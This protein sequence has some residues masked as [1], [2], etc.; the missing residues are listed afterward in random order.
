MAKTLEE[1]IS[2]LSAQEKTLIDNLFAKEPELKSGWLRQDDF[3]RR[4]NELK[5]K[6][7]EYEEAVSYKAKMEPWA[8]VVYDRLHSLEEA[9]VLDAE[10]K[11]LWTEQKT[12]L[13]QELAAAKAT[14]GDMDPAKL[15]EVVDARVK[16]IAKN[17]GGG[18]TKEEIQALNADQAKKLV[19]DGFSEREKKFNS[20][21]IP[22]IAG[23]A[24]ANAVVA[25]RYQ[26]ESGEKWDEK[27][28]SEFFKMMSD[29]GKFDPFALEDKLLSPVKA[30]KEEEARIEKRVQEELAKRGM[31]GGGS[32]RYI[33]QENGQKGALQQAL[34]RSDGGMDLETLIK[35]KAV[36]GAKELVAAGKF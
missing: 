27:K 34:E 5:S 31:P 29:E 6:E 4:Q 13:E 16:E 7:T 22:F 26:Q 35:S 28:Q 33:P 20:E 36:E 24:G 19:E 25:M 14:G 2:G 9:G 10:G 23:F 12:K 11:V 8:D 1:V 3:S 21:T 15:Q 32:E 18:L 30:K 17:F